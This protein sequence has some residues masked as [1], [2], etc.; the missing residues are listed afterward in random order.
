MEPGLAIRIH[1]MKS[2][3][4]NPICFIIYRAIKEP[5]LPS[6]A[7]QWTAIAPFSASHAAR[8]YSTMW[9]G[10]VDPSR[11]YKSRCLIPALVNF[12]LSY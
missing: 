3:G 9:S 12:F 10:G 11:K 7:L 8:N 2:A 4:G 5:V 1:P 6:P